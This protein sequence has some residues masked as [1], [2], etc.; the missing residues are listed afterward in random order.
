M[1][2]VG[3]WT[4]ENGVVFDILVNSKLDNTVH[5]ILLDTENEQIYYDA[6]YVFGELKNKKI[7]NLFQNGNLSLKKM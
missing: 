4:N 1:K 5:E 7:A 3:T 6:G 2:K